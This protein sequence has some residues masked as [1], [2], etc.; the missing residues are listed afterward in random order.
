MQINRLT[1]QFA[2]LSA[3]VALAVLGLRWNVTRLEV[4]GLE[5]LLLERAGVVS[6]DTERR[7]IAESGVVSGVILADA[8]GADPRLLAL[9]LRGPDGRIVAEAV[10]A[11]Q[12]ATDGLPP[13]QP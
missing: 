12:V 13:W 5:V 3:L 6:R 8:R 10:D 7:L 9:Q 1:L 2:G 11:S 4:Q